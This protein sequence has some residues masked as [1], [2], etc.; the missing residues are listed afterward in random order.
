MCAH[1]PASLLCAH[2][3]RPG[4][5][6]VC[7]RCT[8]RRRCCVRWLHAPASP[9]CGHAA[10]AGARGRVGR[11]AGVEREGSRT[12]ARVRTGDQYPDGGSRAVSCASCQSN[13]VAVGPKLR[14]AAA[15]GL[16][17]LRRHGPSHDSELT[18][19]SN[20]ARPRHRHGA[21]GEW[22]RSHA[23]DAG[24]DTDS[25]VFVTELVR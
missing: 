7:A 8:R 20:V 15:S 23:R 13:A 1:A 21:A 22:K 25:A 5:A 6:V 9:L 24:S 14:P 4:V 12:R 16:P 10:R 2:A 11:G 17:G 18:T 3:A 19:G